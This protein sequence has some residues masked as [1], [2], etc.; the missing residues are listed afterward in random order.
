MWPVGPTAAEA[1]LRWPLAV[2][3]HAQ[4]LLV[5]HDV[6]GAPNPDRVRATNNAMYG[7]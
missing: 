5:C 7:V 4:A 2:V 6:R 1:S 3:L